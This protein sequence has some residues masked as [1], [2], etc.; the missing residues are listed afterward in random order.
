MNITPTI[1]LNI[2]ISRGY[3]A[4]GYVFCEPI[5]VFEE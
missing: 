4:V 2:S 1:N 5:F 3:Q